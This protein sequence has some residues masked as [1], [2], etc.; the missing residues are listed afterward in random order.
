MGQFP[1]HPPNR[2]QSAIDTD[3]RGAGG[4]G[5]SQPTVVIAA[6]VGLGGQTISE[7]RH[8][9]EVY[10]RPATSTFVSGAY[11]GKMGR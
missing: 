11:A 9:F 7:R 6:G 3:L 4:T 2:G 1:H 5:R 10:F 8:T